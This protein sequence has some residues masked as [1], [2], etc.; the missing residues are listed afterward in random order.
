MSD[1]Q[2]PIVISNPSDEAGANHGVQ[3]HEISRLV[4]LALSNNSDS[5]NRRLYRLCRAFW[6]PTAAE[7]T[8]SISTAIVELSEKTEHEQELA[9]CERL[10]PTANALLERMEHKNT[11][12]TFRHFIRLLSQTM[13]VEEDFDLAVKKFMNHRK[14]RQKLVRSLHQAFA[15]TDLYTALDLIYEELWVEV[16][17]L[18]DVASWT[19]NGIEDLPYYPN[20]EAILEFCQK[21]LGALRKKMSLEASVPVEARW[22][23]ASI[24][25]ESGWAD[26][27]PFR[28]AD[29]FLKKKEER[30]V[31]KVT[32]AV[33][34]ALRQAIRNIERGG[35]TRQTTAF[36]EMRIPGEGIAH[37]I[38]GVIDR[39]TGW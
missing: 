7:V 37:G 3:A 16:D 32:R 13:Q 28:S 20:S 27:N 25:R 14:Y 39:L 22:F 4:L 15:T 11:E 6:R 35:S 34:S 24:C 1:N 30:R 12:E 23:V 10:L 17:A 31:A 9:F 5:D 18:K 33:Q 19:E 8:A 36:S 29:W 38:E 2:Q 21:L 26:E